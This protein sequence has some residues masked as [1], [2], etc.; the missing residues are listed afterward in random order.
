MKSAVVTPVL[1]KTR[2]DQ[3]ILKNYRPVSNISF[4]SKTLERIVAARLTNYV[5]TNGLHDPLQSAYKTCHST[6]TAPSKSR[7]TFCAQWIVEV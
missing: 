4:L 1:K 6:E 2:L 7:M 5:T 3:Q